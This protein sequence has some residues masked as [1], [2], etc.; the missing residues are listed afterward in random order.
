[1]INDI[2]KEQLA[3][4]RVEKQIAGLAAVLAA[5]ATA[6]QAADDKLQAPVGTDAFAEIQAAVVNLAEVTTRAHE[7]MNA[8]A[9]ELGARMFEAGGRGLPKD[10][11]AS[12]V[13]SI[14]GTG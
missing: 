3:L 7:T 13:A 8:Q 12:V 9:A 14:F 2:R 1:M 11:T 4:L 10:T 6:A 5:G